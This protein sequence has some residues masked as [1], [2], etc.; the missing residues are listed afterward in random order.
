L[1]VDGSAQ[2]GIDVRVPD[3]LVGTIA[4]SPV[5]GGKLKSVDHTPALRV[6]GVK[7]VV[8]LGDAVAVLGEGYWPC[9]KG[10]EA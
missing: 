1:K 10:L 4:A 8:K 3:M 7:S 5:F 9:K 2:F 6:K